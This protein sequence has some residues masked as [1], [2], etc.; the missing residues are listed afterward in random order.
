MWVSSL[1]SGNTHT[2]NGW[3]AAAAESTPEFRDALAASPAPRAALL[4]RVLDGNLPA[5]REGNVPYSGKAEHHRQ[6]LG[7]TREGRRLPV[8]DGSLPPLR[9]QGS[10]MP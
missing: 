6:D 7:S 3:R 4:L 9:K 10:A 1:H 2:P 5:R 8:L